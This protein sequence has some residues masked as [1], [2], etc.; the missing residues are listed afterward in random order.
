MAK[1]FLAVAGIR[2]G[3]NWADAKCI[4]D[5]HRLISREII[6]YMNKYLDE[7]IAD[8]SYDDIRRKDLLLPVEA[9]V[10]LRSAVNPDANPND[11]TRTYALSLRIA[12]QLRLYGTHEWDSTLDL[13]C[14]EHQTLA[15]QL[16]REREMARIPISIK[17]G[18]TLLFSPGPHNLLQKQIIEDFLPL[19]GFGAQVLYVGDTSNKYLYVDKERLESLH[20]DEIAH[21]KLPDVVAYSSSKNWLFL[22]EA[23]YS[24]NP[25]TELRR[26]TLKKMAEKCAAD[27]VYV[28]AFSNRLSFRKHVK[29]IAWETE[30]WIADVPTHLI[31]FNGDKF[32]GPYSENLS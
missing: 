10:V 6:G 4:E 7:N 1:A 24:A 19:F 14:G 11:G 30:V 22:I 26:I 27:V 17:H 15:K 5:G 31:H 13:F 9:G 18:E 16:E 21:G 3:L 2:P 29:D 32:L 12:Q 23:V 8:S 25:I 28:T 20:F